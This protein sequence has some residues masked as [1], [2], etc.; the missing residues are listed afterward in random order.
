MD[1]GS[2]LAS[3][4]PALMRLRRAVYSPEYRAFVE[5]IAGLDP[6]TLTDE[7]GGLG[8]V[9]GRS[10]R[11]KIDLFRFFFPSLQNICDLFSQRVPW[12]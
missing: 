1:D 11:A 10:F 7:V 9:R 6:G 2:D 8:A 12:F 3:K 5:R 4:M